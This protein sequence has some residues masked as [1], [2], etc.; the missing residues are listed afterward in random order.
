MGMER[1]E[2]HAK[3]RERGEKIKQNKRRRK[4]LVWQGKDKT[5]TWAHNMNIFT[6]M[7]L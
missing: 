7:S 3:R 2:W 5:Q 4:E 1:R 6:K